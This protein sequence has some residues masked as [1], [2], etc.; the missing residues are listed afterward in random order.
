M[1]KII[2]ICLVIPFLIISSSKV[3]ALSF[4]AIMNFRAGEAERAY[5]KWEKKWISIAPKAVKCIEKDL[6]ELL[7]F[8]S[9]PKAMWV[10]LR[11][12][13]VIERAFREVRKRTRPMS[14]FNNDQSIERI[15][16]AVLIHLS[17]Q[18]GKLPLKEF[19]QN[20]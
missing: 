16:Y 2:L 17:E 10:K 7:N 19:T 9:C 11:T 13:N 8:Y 12:T 18:W 5:S 20:C 4:E 14:C 15:V 1:R 6:E 3:F